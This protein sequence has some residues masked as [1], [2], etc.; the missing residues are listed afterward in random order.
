MNVS[1]ELVKKE[2]AYIIKN[3]YPLYLHDLA[4]IYGHFPNENGIFEESKDYRTLSDQYDIQNIW[5]QKPDAL[6]PYLIRVDGRPAGFM[7][8]ASTP[9]CNKG[10]D[11]FV[12]EAF[13]LRPF[14]GKGVGEYAAI[15]IFE[16][17]KGKWELFTN[18]SSE[19]NQRGQ[20]FWRK[21]IRNYTNNHFTEEFGET[22]DGYKL[23]FRFENSM[24]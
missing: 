8:I 4:E 16:R 24:C 7:M 14:R 20:Q 12:H 13:L 17:Y 9:Y 21:T 18:P 6:F 11:Y 10:I 23:I 1:V 5:W 3:L 2:E 19:T 22:F 15:A